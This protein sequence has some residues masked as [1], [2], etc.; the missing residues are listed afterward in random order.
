MVRTKETLEILT[1]VVFIIIVI[2]L[3]SLLF[4]PLPEQREVVLGLAVALG[5]VE[6]VLLCFWRSARRMAEIK[7]NLNTT[8]TPYFGITKEDLDQAKETEL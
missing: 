8:Y 6:I 3:F 1:I 2:L 7:L 4:I 5:A